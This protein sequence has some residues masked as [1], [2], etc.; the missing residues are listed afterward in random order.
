VDNA[1]SLAGRIIEEHGQTIG[2]KDS[3]GNTR[4][5]G[6]KSISFHL[7]DFFSLLQVSVGMDDSVSMDLSESQEG[8]NL[9]SHLNRLSPPVR[10]GRLPLPFLFGPKAMG[11][12]TLPFPGFHL[13]K[14]CL[15]HFALFLF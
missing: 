9:L 10:A 15:G 13:Q 3:Q 5:A 8:K 7:P 11:N 14:P 2:G 6:N 4:G 12:P 1:H